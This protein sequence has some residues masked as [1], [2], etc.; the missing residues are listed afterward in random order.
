MTATAELYPKGQVAYTG[1][2]FGAFL[3]GTMGGGTA[4]VRRAAASDRPDFQ[5]HN[6]Y[7]MVRTS[8]ILEY[9]RAIHELRRELLHYRHLILQ[10]ARTASFEDHYEPILGSVDAASVRVLNSVLSAQIPDSA[11]FADFAEGEL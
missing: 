11:F 9:E 10:S 2:A 3:T 4:L 8:V 5:E 6:D 7:V 1:D